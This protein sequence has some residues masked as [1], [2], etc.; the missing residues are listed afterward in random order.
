MKLTDEALRLAARQVCQAMAE[1]L[2]APEDCDHQFSP[3]F[4][5]KMRLLLRRR[6]QH[7]ILHRIAAALLAAFVGIGAWLLVDSDARA[8]LLQWV[9]EVY[10]T[11][12][13][14]HFFGTPGT[15]DADSADPTA[16]A[17]TWLPEGYE[18]VERR[19]WEGELFVIYENE[20]NQ[21]ILFGCS[22]MHDRTVNSIFLENGTEELTEVC[23]LPAAFHQ[24]EKSDSNLL[25]WIDEAQGLYFDLAGYCDRSVMLHIAESVNLV[26]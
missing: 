23:G 21:Q 17:P 13:V 25:I 22:T 14:Y 5:R 11:H 20:E 6:S 2:P 7:P 3:A 4:R 16:W 12:I 10:D 15:G 1:A 9:K 18:E 19:T 26:K 8:D 24:A